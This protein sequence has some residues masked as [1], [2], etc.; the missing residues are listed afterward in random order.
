M[1][2]QPLVLQ[3]SSQGGD[4]MSVIGRPVSQSPHQPP[5]PPGTNPSHYALHQAAPPAAQTPNPHAVT[6][7]YHSNQSYPP[8][9]QVERWSSCPSLCC[10]LTPSCFHVYSTFATVMVQDGTVS[11]QFREVTGAGD[12]LAH[13]QIHASCCCF[14][15]CLRPTPYGVD[16]SAQHIHS[17]QC[18]LRAS[19]FMA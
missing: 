5:F 19:L 7:P 12:L 13:L 3:A 6:S 17:G 2:D 16:Q 10:Q 15:H 14:N 9:N 18:A 11:N 8:Q 1:P 4:W